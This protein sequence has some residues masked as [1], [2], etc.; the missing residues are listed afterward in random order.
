MLKDEEIY[1]VFDTT[2]ILN[3][4]PLVAVD[5]FSG[6]AGIAHWIKGYYGLSDEQ[7]IDKHDPIVQEMK[8][9]VDALYA[10]GRNTVMTTGELREMLAEVA[11]QLYE[12]LEGKQAR[13][14]SK[15]NV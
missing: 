8:R 9:R 2:K 6:V 5:S 14:I 3:R 1:N 11:P 13:Y 15:G 10:Q 12:K 4:P 7:A